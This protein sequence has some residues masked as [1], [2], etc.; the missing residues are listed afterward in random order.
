MV[1]GTNCTV[2]NIS[3]EPYLFIVGEQISDGMA[4]LPTG[5][6]SLFFGPLIVKVGTPYFTTIR[7]EG[8][9]GILLFGT[10]IKTLCCL[11]AMSEGF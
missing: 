1:S 7:H 10:Q 2:H 8:F 9:L 6:T 11:S 4:Y 5:A 3:A